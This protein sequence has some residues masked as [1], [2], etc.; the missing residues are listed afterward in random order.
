MLAAV[1]AVAVAMLTPALVFCVVLAGFGFGLMNV[2]YRLGQQRG[3]PVQSIAFI[4]TLVGAAYFVTC[5]WHAP[6]W[7]APWQAWGLGALVGV[8]QYALCLLIAVALRHGPLSPLNC[9]MFLGFVL[10]ILMAWLAWNE[11]LG[12]LQVV[13]VAVAV[14]CVFC[15]SFQSDGDRRKESRPRT[16]R[17]WLLYAGILF[18]L[19]VVNALAN[20]AFK[21][22]GMTPASGAESY[23][24]RYGN[25][26]LTVL[27]LALGVC[28]GLD[29]LLRSEP[30]GPLRWRIGLGGAAGLGSIT[31]MASLRLCAS[32]PAAFTFPVVAL[33]LILG[34]AL[35]SVFYFGER[36]TRA[37]WAMMVSGS[38]AAGCLIADALMKAG[39]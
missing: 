11:T 28:L 12:M 21:Y 15:A 3:V 19:F 7:Q 18:G 14:L 20:G 6:F 24:S 26:Y 31:G 32:L 4:V 29:L 5:T 16:P 38:V 25:Q 1:V 39:R 13:G 35:V 34:G 37:W 8:S 30:Q 23:A 10:V 17:A 22:L 9:A 36:T 33:T 27:Y 2:A